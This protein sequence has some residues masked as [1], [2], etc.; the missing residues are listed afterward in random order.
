MGVEERSREHFFN[1]GVSLAESG[2]GQADDNRLTK[3]GEVI[4]FSSDM[5][6]LPSRPYIPAPV[7]SEV[8]RDVY[9]DHCTVI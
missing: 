7:L 1:T 9:I 2:V 3:F 5:I 8:I 4:E 6:E